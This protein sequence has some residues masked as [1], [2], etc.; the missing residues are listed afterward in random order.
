MSEQ[1]NPPFLQR[2]IST[3]ELIGFGLSIFGAMILTYSS[4]QV[5]FKELEIR[6]GNV[7]GQYSKI[8]TQLERIETKQDEA[9]ENLHKL[10]TQ[11]INKVDRKN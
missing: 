9:K 6:M 3:G 10:E 11:I 4:I 5:R 1:K 8:S 7:E 2:G